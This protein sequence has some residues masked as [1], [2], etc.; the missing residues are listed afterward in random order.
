M[1]KRRK[2]IIEDPEVVKLQ[3]IL[4]GFGL[5]FFFTLSLQVSVI[6]PVFTKYQDLLENK[7]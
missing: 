4:C 2:S 7:K 1:C 6:W 3:V 5:Q